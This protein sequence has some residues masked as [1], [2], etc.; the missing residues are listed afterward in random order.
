MSSSAITWQATDG[1]HLTLRPARPD[2]AA[3]VRRSLAQLSPEARRQRLLATTQ[4]FSEEFVSSLVDGDPG[5]QHAVLVVREEDGEEIPVAG[6]R[7]VVDTTSAAGR[8]GKN[9]TCEFALV[10]GDRWQGQGIGQN[11]LYALI[12][13]AR[14]RQLRTMVGD[15][16]PDNRSMLTLARK[17]GFFIENTDGD[18]TLRATLDLNAL[19]V[20]QA[21]KD[22]RFNAVPATG[23]GAQTASHSETPADEAVPLYAMLLCAG[24]AMLGLLL[25]MAAVWLGTGWLDGFDY[26]GVNRLGRRFIRVLP[27]ALPLAALAGLLLYACFRC[28]IDERHKGW[29]TLFA[30]IRAFALFPL[31]GFAMLFGMLFAFIAAIPLGLYRKFFHHP[32][33]DE[34]SGSLFQ[35]LLVVPLWIMTLPFTLLKIKSEGDID[36]PARISRSRLINWVPV[37]FLMLLVGP[38]FESE[39]TGNR[40]DANWLAALATYWLA[41]I[42]IVTGYVA[43]TLT[44]RSHAR[45]IAKLGRS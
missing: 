3:R 36:I 22:R 13:E 33:D 10:V 18:S 2:D 1:T 14:R 15:I 24:L 27:W 29:I 31:L 23:N 30:V 42:L 8:T 17:T 6:G 44:T 19:V 4:G 16:L 11:I 7:L 39:Q 38:G 43:P 41:D 28:A 45:R 5:R 25:A 40:V 26:R 34:A 37:F 12:A 21:L 35:S 32:A 9:D 20:K